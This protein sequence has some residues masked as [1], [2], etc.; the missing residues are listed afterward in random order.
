[1][2]PSLFN[3]LKGASLS[4]YRPRRRIIAESDEDEEDE[5]G[6]DAE[7]METSAEE[8]DGSEYLGKYSDSE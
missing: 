3:S 7:L 8:S 5:G 1:M 4:K 6:A 2:I